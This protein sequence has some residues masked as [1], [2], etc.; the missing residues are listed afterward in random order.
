MNV[1]IFFEHSSREYQSCHNLKIELDLLGCRVDLF[2]LHFELDRAIKYSRQYKPEVII[3]PYAYKKSSIN[4][5]QPFIC[6]APIPYIINLHHEETAAPF[7]EH[8]LLPIDEYAKNRVVHFVWTE[9][10]RDNLI[11][12]GVIPELIYITGNIR[13]DLIV[14]RKGYLSRERVSKIFGLDLD[15]R[16]ILYCESGAEL[17]NEAQINDLVTRKQYNKDLLLS[18]N[19][20]L[21]KALD[22]TV[23]DI[24]NLSNEFFEK[25][26]LIYR[27]HPGKF[28]ANEI[29]KTRAKI[30]SELSVYD[31]FE[32]ASICVSRTSTALFEAELSNLLSVRYDPVGYPVELLPRGISEYK[33]VRNLN[34]LIDISEKKCIQQ[35]GVY[36]KYIGE[37]NNNTSRVANTIQKIIKEGNSQYKRENLFVASLLFIHR[38]RISNKWA[39][40]CYKVFPL[41]AKKL[42]ASLYYLVNDI[43]ESWKKDKGLKL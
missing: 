22:K 30:I 14:Q 6:T 10:F 32:F 26:E 29:T 23:N 1:M 21:K 28:V 42:S 15:K 2:S 25:N 13:L 12:A 7:D 20:L 31:W 17:Y 36:K 18:R 5:L 9:K 34:E 40:F 24:S 4:Y 16:W 8:T 37:V 35:G 39:R 11:K 27:P 41:Y 19:R 3:I 43:P 38:K 33:L